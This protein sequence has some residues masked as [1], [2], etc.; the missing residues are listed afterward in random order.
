MRWAVMFFTLALIGATFLPWSSTEHWEMHR[1]IVESE[2]GISRAGGILT[3]VMGLTCIGL[4]FLPKRRIRGAG[5][6]LAGPVG[7]FAGPILYLKS[8]ESELGEYAA[9]LCAHEFGWRICFL[10]GS[11]IGLLGLVELI[12]IKL[13]FQRQTRK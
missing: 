6:L 12:G 4:I 3:L 13:Q 8:L 1:R 11:A 10:A 9:E 7:G 2:S 5:Y